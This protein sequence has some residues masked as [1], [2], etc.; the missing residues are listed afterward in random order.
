MLDLHLA[1]AL[2]PR[3]RQLL[4]RWDSQAVDEGPLSQQ[5]W[6]SIALWP[7]ARSATVAG[8]TAIEGNP[9]T[10]TQV[11]EV[12]AGVGSDARQPDIREVLNYSDALDLSNCAAMRP[13]FEWSQELVRR[14]NAA[15]MAG[16][17]DDEKGEYRHEPV[18]VGGIY[19][20]P[21]HQRLAALMG[22]LVLASARTPASTL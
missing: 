18:T 20:P 10:L 16:L 8:S 13:D 22:D 1:Y 17:D 3:L 2:T 9:L 7:A 5:R 4:G 19:S 12:L 15:V 21:E 14:L 6:T 11:D